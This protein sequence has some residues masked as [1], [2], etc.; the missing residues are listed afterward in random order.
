MPDSS[1]GS[2]T[3]WLKLLAAGD[4]DA[5]RKL[6]EFFAPRLNQLAKARLRT[7]P[8]GGVFDEEDIVQSAFAIFCQR[9]QEG[10]YPEIKDRNELWQ[11]LAVFTSRRAAYH[12]KRL[13]T[14]KRSGTQ[15]PEEVV[16]QVGSRLERVVDDDLDINH[17][18]IADD[19]ADELI[20]ALDDPALEA[21]AIMRLQG[22]TNDEIADKLQLTRRTI[23]RMLNLIRAKW[24]R[25][26][27]DDE[28][29]PTEL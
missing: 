8:Q 14:Q 28:P 29:E 13:Q 3:R 16:D 11:L 23:Q 7:L 24:Q 21:V 1:D 18:V 5:A 17:Q 22:F 25:R 27:L 26:F 2:I 4:H 19:L 6:W 20:K 12:L 15:P 10:R 9:I